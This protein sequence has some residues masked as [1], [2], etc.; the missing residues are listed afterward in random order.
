MVA[1]FLIKEGRE[2]PYLPPRVKEI[3]EG[4]FVYRGKY[5]ALINMHIQVSTIF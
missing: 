1:Y 5:D 4:S 2:P 3:D